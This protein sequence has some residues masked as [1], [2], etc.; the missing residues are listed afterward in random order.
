MEE[1]RFVCNRNG[2]DPI[3]HKLP[4]GCNSLIEENGANLSEEAK[5]LALVRAV[6]KGEILILDEPTSEYD[7][8]SADTFMDR[9]VKEYQEKTMIIITCN[10]Y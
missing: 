4:Y 7:A 8:V 3:I 9:V 1:I 10:K 5:K 6:L 2:I